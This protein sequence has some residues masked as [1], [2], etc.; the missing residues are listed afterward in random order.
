VSTWDKVRS[1]RKILSAVALN[2]NYPDELLTA[3]NVASPM[4]IG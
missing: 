3:Y 1:G 2:N 4:D